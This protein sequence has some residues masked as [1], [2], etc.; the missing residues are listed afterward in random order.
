MVHRC[1][2]FCKH[3]EEYGTRGKHPQCWT[4]CISDGCR[5]KEI[6]ALLGTTYEKGYVHV[7]NDREVIDYYYKCPS[8]KEYDTII[9]DYAQCRTDEEAFAYIKKYCDK[10]MPC[11][12]CCIKERDTNAKKRNRDD[13]NNEHTPAQQHLAKRRAEKDK[14]YPLGYLNNNSCDSN[15]NNSE[16]SSDSE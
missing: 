14:K 5:K 10:T 6:P 3:C 9:C 16:P 13:T 1:Y 8:C 2:L 7:E 12:L 11:R 4:Q 15:N